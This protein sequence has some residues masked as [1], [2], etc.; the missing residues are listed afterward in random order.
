MKPPTPLSSSSSELPTPLLPSSSSSSEEE[1][2]ALVA[3]PAAPAQFAA[4]AT[5][6]AV[7]KSTL[8][9][10]DDDDDDHILGGNKKAAAPAKASPPVVL[11]LKNPQLQPVHFPSPQ[12]HVALLRM[13]EA[14]SHPP[15]SHSPIASL[16][17][18]CRL[19]SSPTT[20]C[21][22]PRSFARKSCARSSSSSPRRVF[23]RSGRLA[24]RTF[25]KKRCRHSTTPFL[26]NVLRVC[27][28]AACPDVWRLR[29]SDWPLRLPVCTWPSS[30]G[31][32]LSW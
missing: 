20:S 19:S 25:G 11:L 28:C 32:G 26:R 24:A 7:A 23:L 8:F 16:A 15:L 2:A 1:P 17:E 6:P 12:P 14:P 29:A 21:C 3:K 10:D 30:R 27:N 18:P 4:V 13:K 9:G 5:K 22:R 31:A